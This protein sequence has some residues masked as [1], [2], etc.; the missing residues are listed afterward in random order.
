MVRDIVVHSPDFR[1][2][3]GGVR[4]AAQLAAW[5]R[6]SLTGLY[7]AAPDAVVTGP[8]A[9]AEEASAYAQDELHQAMLAGR[10]FA[11]WAGRFG[12]HEA[13]WQVAVGGVAEALAGAAHWSD[14]LVLQGHAPPSSTA[15]RLLCDVLLSGAACIVVPPGMAPGRVVRAVV[16]WNG[17]M[18]S[19]RALH[20]ALPLLCAADAV[21]VMYP[22]AVPSSGLRV[23]D[24]VA[25]LRARGVP[26]SAVEP[27]VENDGDVGERLLLRAADERADLL[28]MGASCGRRPGGCCMGT[29]T[30]VVLSG[31][32][33]PVFLRH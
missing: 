9:L 26:A 15:E 12:V 21:T 1:R 3:P 17:S 24:V 16:G 10:D 14:V 25:R 2:W 32:S 13:R 27:L 7:V 8:Q 30:S 29:T 33:V 19:N 11:D 23:A 4:Y 31:S 20:D 22:Q 6:A 5:T 28:V 18:A